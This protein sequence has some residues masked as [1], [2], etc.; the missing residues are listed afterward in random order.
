[1][2]IASGTEISWR[3]FLKFKLFFGYIAF[4]LASVL[5]DPFVATRTVRRTIRRTFRRTVRK[6][7]E[8]PLE[9]W[10][11][12][13]EPLEEPLGVAGRTEKV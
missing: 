7:L 12:L 2:L 6:S 10:T 3:V 11:S 4:L 13:E 9:E 8:K 5:K 1:M